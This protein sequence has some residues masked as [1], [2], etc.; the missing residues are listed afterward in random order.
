MSDKLKKCDV[1]TPEKI[2]KQMNTYLTNNGNLL[3]PSVGIGNLLI[4]TNNYSSV[5]IFDIESSY[6]DKIPNRENFHKYNTDF[7][8]HEFDKKYDNIIM[9][10]P[11]IRIQDLD[12]SYRNFIKTK[13]PLLSKGKY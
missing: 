2:S 11:Y 12:E 10:P 5:D 9:N 13:F 8:K 7:L 1:F 6:L 3:E 4:N